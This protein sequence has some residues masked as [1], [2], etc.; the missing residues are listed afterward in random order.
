MNIE[1]KEI[2]EGIWLMNPWVWEGPMG[3][4]LANMQ[5]KKKAYKKQGYSNLR[6][7]QNYNEEYPYE[8]FGTRMETDE[9]FEKRLKKIKA[10]RAGGKKAKAKRIQAEKTTLKRLA[11]KYPEELK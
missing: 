2:E 8:L 4:V 11:K 9:E 1:K 10:G 7:E 3:M 6:I 5:E